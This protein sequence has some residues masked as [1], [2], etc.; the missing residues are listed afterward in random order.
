MHSDLQGGS[1]IH[2]LR[3]CYEHFEELLSVTCLAAMVL[4]LMLQVGMRWIT[5]NGV[6][7]SEEM[8]RYTFIWA[9][10]AA[11]P[12]LA[13]RAAHVRISA[14]FLLM[15]PRFRLAF[16]MVCDAI[17]VAANLAFAWW[18]W[19]VVRGALEFP[20]I[21]PTLGF[22]RAWVEL[23]IPASFVAMSWRIAEDYL[24][25][26]RRGTLLELVREDIEAAAR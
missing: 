2:P 13:K 25:R 26:W 22:A 24:R 11:A 17:W 4:C 18:S 21:S 7:W 14:Q 23:I 10:F 20:E 15:P 1:P 9:T 5:G 12:M 6:P 16:R 3:W 8:S 19:Q